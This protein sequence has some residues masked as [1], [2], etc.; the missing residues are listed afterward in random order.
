MTLREEDMNRML[1][2]DL[3]LKAAVS[4]H[5]AVH[6]DIMGRMEEET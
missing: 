1:M 2:D 3:G 6:T 4:L 5:D